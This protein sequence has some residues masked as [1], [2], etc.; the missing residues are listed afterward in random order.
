ML[1]ETNCYYSS[2]DDR[3]I[4]WNDAALGIEWPVVGVPLLS[5]RDALG[6]SF[7]SS[8]VFYTYF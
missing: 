2:P 4:M 3:V 6:N 5:I 1:Y 7:A 8:D